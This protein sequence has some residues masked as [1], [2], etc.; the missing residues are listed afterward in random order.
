M[1]R[2]L[3]AA[4]GDQILT[5]SELQTCLFE[6]AQLVNQRPI[7]EHPS[8]PDEGSYLCPNDLI[9]GRASS[10]VPQGPFKERS[11]NTHRLDFIQ[12]I[13]NAFWKRWTREVFPNLVIQRKWHTEQRNACVGDVVLVK[14]SNVVRGE[15]KKALVSKSIKSK[16]GHVR[17]VILT[18][19]S[20]NGTTISVER[21]IQN[22]I[23]L[24]PVESD[25]T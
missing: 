25:K 12:H 11:S 5:F 10:H 3:N 24:V 19:K 14:D 20:I 15:W 6:A 23:V 1:K 16:D 17:R 18:Y 2:A 9:L 4:I 7:G 8:D 21:P 13:V 22:I